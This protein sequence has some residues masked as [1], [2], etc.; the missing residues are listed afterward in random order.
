MSKIF[1]SRNTYNVIATVEILHFLYDHLPTYLPQ[2]K[3]VFH[4]SIDNKR[5]F[6][7]SKYGKNN[8]FAYR[9]CLKYTGPFYH[10]NKHNLLLS[11]YIFVPK[12]YLKRPENKN[13]VQC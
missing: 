5:F 6:H 2:L 7:V 9:K 12:I 11:H 4:L 1:L 10:S 3:F 13:M 8:H